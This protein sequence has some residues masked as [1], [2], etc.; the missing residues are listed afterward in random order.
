MERANV[1]INHG[2]CDLE[3]MSR[4]PEFKLDLDV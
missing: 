1:E 3:N 4:W 2:L